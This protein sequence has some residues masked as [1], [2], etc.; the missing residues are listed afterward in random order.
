M[1]RWIVL[2]LSAC[3]LAAGLACDRLG[4]TKI[5]TDQPFLDEPSDHGG[6]K[7]RDAAIAAID[8]LFKKL[9]ELSAKTERTGVFWSNNGWNVIPKRWEFQMPYAQTWLGNR[10]LMDVTRFAPALESTWGDVAALVSA[11]NDRADPCPQLRSQRECGGE[12]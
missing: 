10:Q 9:P 11:W 4:P 6:S 3:V 12:G 5:P 2:S 8:N 1:N 7:K